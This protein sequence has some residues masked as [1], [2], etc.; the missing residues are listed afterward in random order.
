MARVCM[1][2]ASLEARPGDLEATN[3]QILQ[4]GPFRGLHRQPSLDRFPGAVRVRRYLAGETLFGQGEPGWTA[5][6]VLTQAEAA[7]LGR[8][9]APAPRPGPAPPRVV[10]AVRTA[11]PGRNLPHRRRLLSAPLC[12]GEWVGEASCRS[13]TP[14]PATVLLTRP[15]LVLEV[16]SN[17]LGQLRQD[18][19]F[20]LQADERHRQRSAECWRH[21]SLFTWLSDDLYREVKD[22][23]R[24][25]IAGPGA[26]VHAEHEPGEG[27]YVVQTGL[28]REA[29]G[30]SPLLAD[31][32][33]LDGTFLAAPARATAGSRAR[34]RF[35]QLV[36][37]WAADLDPDDAL[38]TPQGPGDRAALL[39]AV[40]RV[41]SLPG[42]ADEPAFAGLAPAGG[43]AGPDVRRSNRLLLEAL[44]PGA[45]RPLREQD[46]LGTVVAYRG[47][48]EW[49]GEQ[50]A[51]AGGPYEATWTAC[52]HPGD[53]G[54]VELVHIPAAA[55][56]LLLH[57]APEVRRRVEQEA[58]RRGQEAQ[59]R[60]RSPWWRD[61]GPVQ[62]R[63]AF[64]EL[65]LV[66]G[67]RLMLIDLDR[68]T[69]CNEC[70][71]ACAAT[72]QGLPRLVLDGPRLGKYLA[73]TTCRACLDPVCLTGCPVGAIHR[74]KQQQ[75][76]VED[77][78]IG[79]G[80]CVDNCPYGA[81]QKRDVG[82]LPERQPWEFM[83]ACQGADDAGPPAGW[84]EP[85]RFGAGWLVG[86]APFHHDRELL[87]P[88][89]ARGFRRGW[90]LFRCT[91]PV[92]L[93]A[94]GACYRLETVSQADSV[95]VWVN[96]APARPE[97]PAR[98][99][100]RTYLL[101]QKDENRGPPLLHPGRNTV[102][103]AVLF[104]GGLAPGA[105]VWGA[106]VDEVRPP[107]AREGD[108]EKQ[109]TH[110]A[111][112]CDLCVDVPGGQPVCVRVCPHEA[113]VRIDA[114]Q[115]F[116]QDVG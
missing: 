49:F 8:G 43:A 10:A 111:A 60:V 86:E 15:C 72:H 93:P 36:C 64:E 83:P 104:P 5:F 90:L 9:A 11:G 84:Q 79:C 30:A 116:P 16:L 65:G 21:F 107:H 110:Q 17:V 59:A 25:V 38:A 13:R 115:E 41:L 44:W 42:L 88:L 80:L 81:L 34:A 67:Q 82:V 57:A 98:Q 20:R 53:V 52:G 6:Y 32:A 101:N 73:P 113:A 96:G 92:G 35:W 14:R 112:G 31:E 69:R 19:A 108:A 54:V 78:C 94:A 114:R 58:D 18:P 70:V 85:G 26:V 62:T 1:P 71:A 4:L 3:E 23:L 68:C 109:V 56:R 89:A 77:W 40:N 24:L 87:G 47:V 99:G 102:A 75:I 95:R 12:E 74:G 66:Q 39:Q 103:A 55:F 45:V 61:A 106:R 63:A 29:R 46:G 50:S 76:V 2:R 28:V 48:G 22:H 105:V 33:V 27:V 51:L 91:F 7:A 97:G 37:E 100:R